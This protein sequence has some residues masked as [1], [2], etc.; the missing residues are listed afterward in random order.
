MK[1]ESNKSETIQ[2]I[3]YDRRRFLR[4]AAVTIVGA[5]LSRI[6]FGEAQTDTTKKEN[7]TSQ[8]G[9]KESIRP[10]HV[11]FPEAEL[12]DLRRRVKATKWP[13]KETVND[14]SQGV[15]LATMQKLA[16]Y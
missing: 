14:T 3:N 4:S 8:P 1:P 15:Q 9:D 12:T 10:F 2:G 7:T 5:E 6:K 11:S 16:R 13:P